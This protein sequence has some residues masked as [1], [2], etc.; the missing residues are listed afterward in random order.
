MA[1]KC[2]KHNLEEDMVCMGEMCHKRVS[3]E[4]C[5]RKHDHKFYLDSKSKEIKISKLQ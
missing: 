1:S 2:K 5:I 3:C 4:L